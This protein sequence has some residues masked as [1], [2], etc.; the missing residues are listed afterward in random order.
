MLAHLPRSKG[1]FLPTQICRS[2]ADTTSAFSVR[3]NHQHCLGC[4]SLRKPR[5]GKLLCRQEYALPSPAFSVIG[6]TCLFLR[7]GSR[8]FHEDTRKGGYQ[9][10]HQ[11]QRDCAR[12]SFFRPCALQPL[13]TSWF[14][15]RRFLHDRNNHAPRDA[16]APHARLCCP[17][18]RCP[19]RTQGEPF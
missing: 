12:T 19:L 17:R 10:Q 1:T 3:P 13:L 4:R 18:R 7:S 5:T 2:S 15:D 6:L 11:G 9:V 16:Q 8:R 14:A